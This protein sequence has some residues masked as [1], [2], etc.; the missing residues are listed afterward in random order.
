MNLPVMSAE[1]EIVGMVD[2]LKLTYATLDQVCPQSSNRVYVHHLTGHRSTA[3]R[4]EIAKDLPGTSSG[5][6]STTR[7]SP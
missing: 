5:C 4:L 2:V 3:C 7:P 6:H 1:G